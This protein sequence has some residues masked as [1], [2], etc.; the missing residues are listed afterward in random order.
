[1]VVVAEVGVECTP[2]VLCC[3]I[4]FLGPSHE[5]GYGQ[6]PCTSHKHIFI[7][8]CLSSSFNSSM[9]GP[10]KSLRW[11]IDLAALYLELAQFC[12]SD[13]R[14]AA[15]IADMCIL[16]GINNFMNMGCWG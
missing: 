15:L 7:I 10:G 16:G 3:L 14:L 13:R 6:E 1:M 12:C 5:K 8:V 4:K 2:D 9:K 11:H